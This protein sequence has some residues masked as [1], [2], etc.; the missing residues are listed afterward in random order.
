MLAD[1]RRFRI[2]TVVDDFTRECQALVVDTSLSGIRV[3]RERDTLVTTRGRPAD[4]GQRQRHR[5][6]LA[7]DPSL[8]GGPGGG[9]ALH[10]SRQAD[11]ERLRRK[12]QSTLPRRCLNEH[13]FRGLSAARAI[14]E[15]W[16][17]DYNARRPHTSSAGSPPTS[18]Q[19]GP[20]TTITRTESSYP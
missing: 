6:D 14:I 1:G 18:S 12:L 10:P 13:L 4:D 16:W 5:A 3:A 17:I 9:V 19:P 11:A 7:G 8:A 20:T 2:L 15:D